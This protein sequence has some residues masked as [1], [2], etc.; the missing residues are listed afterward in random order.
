MKCCCSNRVLQEY[1]YHIGI[2]LQKLSPL[3]MEKLA[4][5]LG[6]NGASA[7]SEM[8][9][10]VCQPPPQPSPQRPMAAYPDEGHNVQ[11]SALQFGANA[12]R[13][14]AVNASPGLGAVPP[15]RLDALGKAKQQ[16]HASQV[17]LGA[18]VHLNDCTDSQQGGAGGMSAGVATG[19]HTLHGD[20]SNFPSAR[21][22]SNV[23]SQQRYAPMGGAFP[24][25][26]CAE[27]LHSYLLQES[28]RQRAWH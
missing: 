1:H 11:G 8:L 26:Q 20:S 5:R 25:L 10:D 4:Q 13:N 24:S 27:Q 16:G 14:G 2:A 3:E 28:C 23:S 6:V 19:V 18:A 17:A 7:V 15:L 9:M 22:Q 12:P 21:M